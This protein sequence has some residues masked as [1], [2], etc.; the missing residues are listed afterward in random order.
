M[1]IVLN[2]EECIGCGT[3]SA[4]CPDFWEI[5]E[6]EMKADLKGAE[7]KENTGMFELEID[8]LKC[9]QEAADCCPVQC[10][11]IEK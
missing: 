10:I 9:N 5:N 1:K 8:D 7:K 2:R 11:K 6:N 4:L 3:C